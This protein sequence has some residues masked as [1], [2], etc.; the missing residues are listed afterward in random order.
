[1]TSRI[2]FA[3]SL[4]DSSALR[5]AFSSILKAFCAIEKG[6]FS[7]ATPSENVFM[8]EPSSTLI[9]CID[10]HRFADTRRGSRTL[11]V[12]SPEPFG[13]LL[14]QYFFYLTGFGLHGCE[15]PSLADLQKISSEPKYR[16]SYP[17]EINQNRSFSSPQAQFNLSAVHLLC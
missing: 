17:Q 1:M 14:S 11:F 16:R 10:Y 6:T 8:P 13:D 4:S 5:N 15:T 7:P 3:D 2:F 9:L 12:H